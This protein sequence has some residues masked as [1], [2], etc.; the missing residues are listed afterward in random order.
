MAEAELDDEY[1]DS[2]ERG[3][4][5][6]YEWCDIQNDAV[7]D[8]DEASV[9]YRRSIGWY[10]ERKEDERGTDVVV[11]ALTSDPSGKHQ[12]SGWDCLPVEVVLAVEVL[13]RP[14]RRNP[15]KSSGKKPAGPPAI[16]PDG[17]G[18]E[19]DSQGTEETKRHGRGGVAPPAN[20]P[21]GE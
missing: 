2:L 10:W 20:S 7:G 13:K 19:V 1:W 18:V 14:R 5:C 8:P 17:N 21:E 3:T 6:E 11:F 4:L 12:Q 9:M 15:K 16:Q